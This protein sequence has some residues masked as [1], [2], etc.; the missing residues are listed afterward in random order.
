MDEPVLT[1]EQMRA[2]ERAAMDAGISTVRTPSTILSRFAPAGAGRG[3]KPR[4]AWS[5][6][7][8]MTGCCHTSPTAVAKTMSPPRET[9]WSAMNCSCSVIRSRAS[10]GK[11]AAR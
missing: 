2:A 6:S 3:R 11:P 5:G 1:V 8:V 4:A 10:K 7:M 9:A